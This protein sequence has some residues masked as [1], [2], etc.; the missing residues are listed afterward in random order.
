[1]GT[2]W[3]GPATDGDGFGA[4]VG[5]TGWLVGE[6]VA[7]EEVGSGVGDSVRG[8]WVGDSVCGA[9]VGTS[10]KTGLEVG[11]WEEGT[12]MIWIE[13]MLGPPFAPTAV[14]RRVL[15]PSKQLA[16]KEEYSQLSHP[17][18][19]AKTRTPASTPFSVTWQSRSRFLPPRV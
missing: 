10:A 13:S 12:T 5:D 4:V 11:T 7:G 14:M 16:V 15:G 3:L 2:S 9:A 17:P 6:L 8:A 1:M 19:P 18:V